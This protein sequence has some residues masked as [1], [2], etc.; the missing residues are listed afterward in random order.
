[1]HPRTT[2]WTLARLWILDLEYVKKA[3]VYLSLGRVM[4]KREH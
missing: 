4:S 1:L 3:Q 2:D